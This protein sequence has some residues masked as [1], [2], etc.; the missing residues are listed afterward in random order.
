MAKCR[1]AL[2]ALRN[3]YDDQH[4]LVVAAREQLN[5]AESAER[6]TMAP[7]DVLRSALDRQAAREAEKTKLQSEVD[8]LADKL[9]SAK[10]KLDVVTQ[11]LAESNEEVAKA[12]L[13]NASTAAAPLGGGAMA[14]VAALQQLL[15]EA[16][17][18]IQQGQDRNT[19]GGALLGQLVGHV[20]ALGVSVA[21]APAP[22]APP[23][24]AAT[25]FRPEPREAAAPVPAP[26]SPVDPNE[27][28]MD[29]GG[30]QAWDQ[31]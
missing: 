13:A 26:G 6:A 30:P 14:S 2:R 12:Q 17:T 10:E 3:I 25:G 18:S 24:T 27:G 28:R 21:Q 31:Y 23:T 15:Q 19:V 11:Q 5:R 8:E 20:Q 7:A 1:K 29:T 16:H 22:M 4:N 9:K